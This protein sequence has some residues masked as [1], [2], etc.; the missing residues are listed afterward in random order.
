MKSL[1]V[2]DVLSTSN[3]IKNRITVLISEITSIDQAFTLTEAEKLILNFNYDI[4]FWDVNL[5]KGTS[6]DLLKQ[7]SL[8]D[9]ITF[10]SIFIT[11]EKESEYVINALKFSA[12]DYLLKPL[13]DDELIRSV[14]KAI[15]KRKK[16]I[17]RKQIELLIE[18]LSDS[19]DFNSKIAFNLIKGNIE[20]VHL[21]DIIMLEADGVITIIHL[22]DKSMLHATKNLGFYKSFL[23]NEVSFY[24]VSHSAIVN[25][26]AIQNV[27][28]KNLIIYFVNGCSTK[29]S[30]RRAKE[31]KEYF[32]NYKPSVGIVE[33]ILK[34]FK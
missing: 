3:L 24:Q 15:E 31:F 17:D 19:N 5:P 34:L 1:I 12:I 32:K 25:L 7:L 8:K 26:K 13:D 14:K 27:D 6:F 16:N 11:G 30:R 21:G 28:L 33:K 29:I 18:T 4:I 20:Y 9:L 23:T 2:E 10:E 22:K